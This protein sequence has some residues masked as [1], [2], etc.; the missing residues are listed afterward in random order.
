M[1]IDLDL[2]GR[3]VGTLATASALLPLSS[4]LQHITPSG[5]QS[6]VR[7]MSARMSQ[8]LTRNRVRSSTWTSCAPRPDFELAHWFFKA[9]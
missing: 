4:P 1:P 3:L 7:I 5:L 8:R 2:G 9:M 6:G